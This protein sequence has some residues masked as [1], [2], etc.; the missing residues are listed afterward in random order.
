MICRLLEELESRESWV[1]SV[2][3]AG[4]SGKTSKSYWV[5]D[6]WF[7]DDRI[8]AYAF[9]QDVID[10]LPER[11]SSR[12]ESFSSFDQIAGRPGIIFLDDIAIHFLSRNSNAS[13]SKDMVATM[14]IARHNGHRFIITTQNSIL[15]D[16]GLMESLDNFSLR[17]RMTEIQMLTEREEYQDLQR[18]V[19][20]MIDTYS[21]LTGKSNKGFAY[22]SETDELL[23][24]P[25][26]KDMTSEIS[27]PYQGGYVRDG[28]LCFGGS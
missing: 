25:D 11:I 19:N 5:L 6:N 28:K 9:R 13:A 27:R 26:W 16:K 12:M 20:R 8:F 22:C 14:T 2:I 17:T 24:F 18:Q 23:R 4:G 15:S 7:P 1:L 10:S 3:G 21:E